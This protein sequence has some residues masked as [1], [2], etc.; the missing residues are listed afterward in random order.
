MSET[1]APQSKI[2]MILICW[3]IGWTGLHRKM[4]GYENWWHLLVANILCGAG[5]LW[6]VYDLIMLLIGSMKMAD[7]SDLT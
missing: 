2:T 4:M 5:V 3:F 1:L 6:A 7:G